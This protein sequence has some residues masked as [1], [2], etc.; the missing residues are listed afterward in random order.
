MES[1]EYWGMLRV[2]GEKVSKRLP[3]SISQAVG[4]YAQRRVF[5]L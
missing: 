4:Q 3:Y 1:E 5:E 2:D